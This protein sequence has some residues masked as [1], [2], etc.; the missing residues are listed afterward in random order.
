MTVRRPLIGLLSVAMVALPAVA[1]TPRYQPWTDPNRDATG[2]AGEFASRLRTLV[3]EAERSKAADPQFLRDLRALA[4][5]YAGG[6]QA[7]TPTPVARLDETFADGDFTRDPT[8]TVT[9][10][11]FWIE[12]GYGLRSAVDRAAATPKTG[13]LTDEQKA[14]AILGAVLGAQTGVPAS[15]AST[16][17]TAEI[18]VGTPIDNAFSIRLELASWRA[19]GRLEIG[20]GQRAHGDGGYRLSYDGG[21]WEMLR[22]GTRGSEVI[23]VAV[24]R[25]TIE[26]NRMHDIH[27]TRDRR[28]RMSVVLDGAVL[29]TARD[30]GYR[31]SFDRLLLTNR[32]GDFTL[33]R[34]TVDGR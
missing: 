22:V 1:Q 31:D 16:T 14:L 17:P 6:G 30:N 10:G 29:L 27:W 20:P 2:T 26:D 25:R 12:S 13:D 15:G 24:T 21:R 8:W 32:G 34:V 33:R 18:H 5:S 28:G 7:T 11:K 4:D 19:G 9:A 3:D 23:D